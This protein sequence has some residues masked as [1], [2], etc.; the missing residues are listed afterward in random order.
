MIARLVLIA[1]VIFGGMMVNGAASLAA[2][3]FDGNWSVLIVTNDGQCDPAYRYGL[4][5]RNGQVLYEG[6]ASVNVAGR[7]SGNGAVTVRV[8]A[9][10]QSADGTGRLSHAQG[11]GSWRGA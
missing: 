3:T 8:S 10:S 11:S 6:D 7:V 4:V 5:I 2:T 1:C 9:G